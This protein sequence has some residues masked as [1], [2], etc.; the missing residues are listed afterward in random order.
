MIAAF[1]KRIR[2][3]AKPLMPRLYLPSVQRDEYVLGWRWGVVCGACLAT[4]VCEV[5]RHV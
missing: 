3:D 4:I 2:P 1:W 5:V